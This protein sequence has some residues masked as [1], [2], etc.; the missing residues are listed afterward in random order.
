M[1]DVANQ[2]GDGG[3][4][5]IYKEVRRPGMDQTA[6]LDAVG[7]MTVARVDDAFKTAVRARRDHFLETSLLSDEL[8][9]AE[10]VRA[11]AGGTS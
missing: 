10:N 4:Q 1:L 2:F 3:A 8:F 7:D 5:G 6:V 9:S 11:A